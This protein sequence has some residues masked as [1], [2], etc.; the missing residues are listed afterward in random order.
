MPADPK[1]IEALLTPV[2][3]DQPAGKDLRYDPRY[4]Q[5]K[6]A[7]REDLELP[8]GGLATDRKI[9][10]W[11][12]VVKLSGQLLSSETKDLQLAA[13]LSEALLKRDGLSGLVTG[14]ASLR[15]I[16]ERYWDH[17]Y[18]AWDE[19]DPELRAGPL[20][21]VGSRLD[22][23]A[24]Q[25]AIAPGGMSLL[26][27]QASRGIRSEADAAGNRDAAGAREEAPADGKR[28]PEEID[29]AI[30]GAPKAFYKALIAE[31]DIAMAATVALEKASDERFGRD[32]PS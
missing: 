14:L 24:R 7:R 22:V 16:L 31:T 20:E 29:G 11:P 19:D 4:D 27:Y 28:M 3:G 32:A 9:A 1:L 10:D 23:A 6:E 13:W 8:P 25:T 30:A 15:S 18:P 17:C 2:P 5:V 26:D 12:H 21:W